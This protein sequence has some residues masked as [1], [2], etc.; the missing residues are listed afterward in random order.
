MVANAVK[1]AKVCQVLEEFKDLGQIAEI[2]RK[3]KKGCISS[4]VDK[5][6]KEVSDTKDIAEVFADFY[7]A[8]YKEDSEKVYDY[9]VQGEGMEVSPI[10]PK[11]VRSQ[12]KKMKKSKAADDAGIVCELLCE[13]SETLIET[14]ADMFT[15]ILQP[16]ATLPPSW[17]SSSIRVLFKKGDPKIPGNYRPVCII[18]ILYKLFSKIFCERIKGN[19]LEAQSEDQ[20]GFRPGFSCEDHLFT[21]TMLAE[22]SNGF[23]LIYGWLR[24]TSSQISVFPMLSNCCINLATWQCQP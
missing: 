13:G 12:L 15:S 8:L 1:T 19:L 23:V 21:I 9:K 22:K 11:E 4:I 3:G 24:S 10:T 20:A 7:E 17:K 18:P 5:D 14:I 2:K 6:G 16:G